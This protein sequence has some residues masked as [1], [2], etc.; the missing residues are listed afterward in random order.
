MAYILGLLYKSELEL[1]PLVPKDQAGNA[2]IREKVFI[3]GVN[4]SYI[5]SGSMEVVVTNNRTGK[6][7][8]RSVRSDHGSTLGLLQVVTTLDR[9]DQVLTETG[10][11]LLLS[12]GRAEDVSITITSESPLP[13]RIAAVS[14]EGTYVE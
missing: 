8:T 1:T 2:L 5:D 3:D 4:L 13:I 7:L 9:T 6:I 14:Q 11:R 12:R 10:R